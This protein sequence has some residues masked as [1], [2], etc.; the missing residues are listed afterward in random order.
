MRDPL[1]ALLGERFA[2]AMISI[3]EGSKNRLEGIRPG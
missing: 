3:E 2:L 1:S